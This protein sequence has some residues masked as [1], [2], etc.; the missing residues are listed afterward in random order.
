MKHEDHEFEAS[1]SCTARLCPNKKK[2]KKKNWKES[3]AFSNSVVTPEH[4]SNIFNVKWWGK[5]R[6]YKVMEWMKTKMDV[7]NTVIKH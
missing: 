2:K 7:R 6:L 3:S 1:L 5:S 4:Y